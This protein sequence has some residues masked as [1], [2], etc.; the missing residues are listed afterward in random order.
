MVMPDVPMKQQNIMKAW[1]AQLQI[2][3]K[4]IKAGEKAFVSEEV[5]LK[6]LTVECTSNANFT[7][8]E[9]HFLELYPGGLKGFRLLGG[10]ALK[11]K[12]EQRSSK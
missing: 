10:R 3:T 1:A 4:K 7:L 9:K 12:D 2:N 11:K 8:V 6:R 5:N